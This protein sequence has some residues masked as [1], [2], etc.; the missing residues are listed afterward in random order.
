MESFAGE[1]RRV[2]LTAAVIVVLIICSLIAFTLLTRPNTQF[3]RE[4]A[5]AE[6]SN[7]KWLKVEITTS[8]NRYEYVQGEP[9]LVLVHYSSLAPNMYKADSADGSGRAAGSEVLHISNGQKR[10]LNVTGIVC[11][12]ARLIGLDDNPFTPPSL[13]PLTLAPGDYEIYV[14][15]R[16]VFKWDAEGMERYHPSAFEVA[17]NML[18]IRVLASQRSPNH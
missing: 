4:Q 17:S 13:T 11:C 8:D 15:S 16:R 5:R 7:P 2:T 3:E 1:W 14:T 12:D 18:K 6:T 10:P 9:I